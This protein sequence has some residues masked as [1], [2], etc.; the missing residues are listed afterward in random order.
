M[1][2]ASDVRAAT[3]TAKPGNPF[4]APSLDETFE[5]LIPEGAESGKIPAGD[6]YIGK[7]ISLTKKDSASSGN[8]MWVWVFTIVSGDYKG[9]DFTLWTSLQSNA[10]WKIA[11]TLTAMGIPWSPGEPINFSL[12]DVLGTLVRLAIKDDKRDGRELSKLDRILPHP[13][14]AGTKGKTEFVVPEKVDDEEEEQPRAAKRRP[15]PV[16]DDE[17]EEPVAP[18]AKRRPDPEDEEEWPE[19]PPAPARKARREPDPEEDPEDEEPV[20]PAARKKSRL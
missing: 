20:R 2:K 13:K 3:R 19:P 14:G 11:D 17:E 1:A 6:Q 12:R 4:G 7:L 16:E 9:L 8:P 10:L 15:P 18:K 5:I